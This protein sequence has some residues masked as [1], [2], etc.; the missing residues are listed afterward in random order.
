MR[1]LI[2]GCGFPQLGL[3]RAARSLGLAIVGVD[4]SPQAIG[5]QACDVFRE[6]STDDTE[7][8]ARAVR[9]TGATGLCTCGSEVALRAAADAAHELGLP[10]Y[11]DPDTVDRCQAKD[12]MREAYRRGGAPIP[13]FAVA[14][15]FDAVRSFA[16]SHGLPIILKPSRG[17]GQRGVSKVETP[18]EL[19]G[20]FERAKEASSTGALLAEEFIAGDEVSVNAYTLDGETRVYSVTE[21]VITA[22]PDPPGITFA[23]WY[24]SGLTREREAAAI[25]AAVRGAKALGVVRGPTYTQIRVGS[26]GAFLVETAHRLGGG[27]DPDVAMLASG[28]S[29]FRKI[30]GVAL[31]RPD[32][33]RDEAREPAPLAIPGLAREGECH[34]GAI[35]K[36]IVGRPGQVV[37]VEGLR[38]ARAMPGIVAA[39]VYVSVGGRVHPLTDGSKRAGHV[40]AYGQDREQARARAEQAVAAIRIETEA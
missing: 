30:L 37:R 15:D 31:G 23:E 6:V 3:L 32:W 10:F 36:F 19:R 5:V 20:A 13:A 38:E 40:L 17:W 11:A 25:D 27:L 16:L 22:Y 21:R 34:G 18:S 14:E 4:R 2:V 35:G 24:P 33:E 9:D 7:G 26:E 1:V 29:L 12:R 28:V 39:E 8:I